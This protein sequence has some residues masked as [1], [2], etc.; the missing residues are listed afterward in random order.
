M[1][2]YIVS[3]VQPKNINSKQLT[4][5]RSVDKFCKTSYNLLSHPSCCII[6]MFAQ[7]SHCKSCASFEGAESQTVFNVGF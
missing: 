5:Q 3:V 2:F 6:D 7:Y 4:F 1:R